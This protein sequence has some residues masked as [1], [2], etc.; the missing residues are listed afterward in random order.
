MRSSTE[1][2]KKSMRRSE[3]ND[4]DAGENS[5]KKLQILLADRERRMG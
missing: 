1:L 5:M 4:D 2:R 3:R